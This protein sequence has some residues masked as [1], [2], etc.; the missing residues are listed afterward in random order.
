MVHPKF[1]SE[2]KESQ[3]QKSEMKEFPKRST[4]FKNILILPA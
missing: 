3:I 1:I 4:F 2:G